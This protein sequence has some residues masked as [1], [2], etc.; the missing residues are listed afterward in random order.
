MKLVSF[1]NNKGE[2]RAGFIVGD[3]TFDLQAAGKQLGKD[4][5]PTMSCLLN[6]GE[7]AMA[8]VSEVVNS[9]EKGTAVEA[10]AGDDVQMLAPVPHPPSCRDAYAFRQH[11][12][13]ARRNRGVEMIPEFDQYPVFYFTNHNGIIGEGDLVVEV[14]H[15]QKLDFELEAAIVIGKE[16]RN[17]PASGADD[18]TGIKV[19]AIAGA[20][21]YFCKGPVHIFQV[22]VGD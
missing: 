10:E 19:N 8:V 16:G 5:P 7:G 14:D 11:V 2:E 17:I 4:L 12:A 15:L 9:A 3:K 22:A 1:L 18:I 6:A 20:F 21:D 13:T